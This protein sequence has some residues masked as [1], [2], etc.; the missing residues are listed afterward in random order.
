MDLILGLLVLLI[1]AWV[2]GPF[3]LRQLRKRKRDRR[4]RAWASQPKIDL[5]DDSRD[6]AADPDSPRP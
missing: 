1:V 4:R 6:P 5:F 2:A 3:A